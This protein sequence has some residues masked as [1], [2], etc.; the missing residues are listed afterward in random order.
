[1]AKPC[2]CGRSETGWCQGLHNKPD[3]KPEE[4]E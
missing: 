4:E 3:W 2:T 1:M